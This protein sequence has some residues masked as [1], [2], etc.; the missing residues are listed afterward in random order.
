M[1]PQFIESIA[2][3]TVRTVLV[4]SGPI[5]GVALLVGLL[6]SIFQATTQI[7]EMTLAYIPK[8]IA[9]YI[10]LL[11]FAGFMLERLMTFTIRIFSDFSRYLL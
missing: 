3:E 7:N 6:V 11:I 2:F 10:T 8:I 9:I 5:L 1:T 4:V